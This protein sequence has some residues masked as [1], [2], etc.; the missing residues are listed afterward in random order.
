MGPR[1]FL[2]AS[3]IEK[4]R[5]TSS[6]RRAGG[7]VDGMRSLLG[8]SGRHTSGI[9]ILTLLALGLGCGKAASPSASGG[10]GGAATG[11]AVGS[12]G[13]ATGGA[14]GSGGAATGGAGGAAS[15]GVGGAASGG[16]GGAASVLLPLAKSGQ[17]LKAMALIANEAAQFQYIQDSAFGEPCEFVQTADGQ[18]LLCVPTLQTSVTYLDAQ[19]TQ[20]VVALDSQS[21][22]PRNVTTE[23][24]PTYRCPGKFRPYR[25]T[26][27]VAELVRDNQLGINPYSKDQDG[28]CGPTLGWGN[29]SGLFHLSPVADGD[30]VTARRDVIPIGTELAIARITAAD[31]AVFTR[32]VLTSAGAPC[33]LQDNGACVPEPLAVV[34]GVESFLDAQC[35][36][37]SW[38][39]PYTMCDAPQYTVR[40]GSDGVHIF[41]VKKASAEYVPNV[42]PMTNTTICKLFATTNISVFDVQAEVT[43]P[44]AKVQQVMTVGTGALRLELFVWPDSN[45]VPIPLA[46]RQEAGE[47][48]LPGGGTCQVREASDGTRRCAA[49]DPLLWYNNTFADADCKQP[50]FMSQKSRRQEP[51]ALHPKGATT[52][53][54]GKITA[55]HTVQ[56]F[57]G[58][59]QYYLSGT[60]CTSTALSTLTGQVL[61]YWESTARTE[62]ASLPLVELKAL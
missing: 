50:L 31:G 13:A 22:P 19:C 24:R 5:E 18:G 25:P 34:S 12:G 48:L 20:P 30:L 58:Q 41:S 8:F 23:V 52:D 32:E 59:Q 11:G 27:K 37:R 33:A 26:Y 28:H 55:V 7:I 62:I 43:G 36:R 61:E 46:A 44:F 51:A 21:Q 42:D 56:A 39:S 14:V 45:G 47:F 38:A 54:T 53:A 35:S 40:I 17:R 6:V 16:V 15:G 57:S 9:V 2:S 60:T 10:S 1:A 49:L 29:R 3:G 4:E